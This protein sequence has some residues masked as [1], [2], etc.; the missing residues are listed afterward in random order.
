MLLFQQMVPVVCMYNLQQP[1]G[2]QS[3][4][5]LVSC[6]H[7][8]QSKVLVAYSA[9]QSREWTG[10]LAL[11][12]SSVK[13]PAALVDI[14]ACLIA[15]LV[16]Q[17]ACRVFNEHMRPKYWEQIRLN[18]A[19]EALKPEVHSSTQAADSLSGLPMFVESLRDSQTLQCRR[20]QQ[21]YAEGVKVMAAPFMQYRRP[22]QSHTS[23]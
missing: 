20:R 7:H 12:R 2:H 8:V 16:R 18:L 23:L 21:R 11:L 6:H 1:H 19:M 4:V 17:R 22:A 10:H 9:G 14:E 13:C 3:K 5:R 15:C